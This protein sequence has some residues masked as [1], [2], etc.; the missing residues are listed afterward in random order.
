MT[1]YKKYR[2]APLERYP[3]FLF[4]TSRKRAKTQAFMV[5]LK[6]RGS[7]LT[8]PRILTL[9]P[10]AVSA[11][12]GLSSGGHRALFRLDHRIATLSRVSSEW[13]GSSA[14]VFSWGKEDWI[15]GSK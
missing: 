10:M 7:V 4:F 11:S 12:P 2:L 1:A 3:L 15:V 5:F 14:P 8:A 13:I 6:K 9:E